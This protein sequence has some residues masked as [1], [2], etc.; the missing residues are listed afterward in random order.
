MHVIACIGS[1]TLPTIDTRN[2]SCSREACKGSQQHLGEGRTMND[3]VGENVSLHI[4]VLL[5]ANLK[6]LNIRKLNEIICILHFIV[7]VQYQYLH[8]KPSLVQLFYFS[9]SQWAIAG[10]SF[11]L[12][13]LAIHLE[14]CYLLDICYSWF[15]REYNFRRCIF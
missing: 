8:E 1:S 7:M 9:I 15:S 11:L 12:W 4:A 5:S 3:A 10:Y 6:F 13:L 14:E 2:V